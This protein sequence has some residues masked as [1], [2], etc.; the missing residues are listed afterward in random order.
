MKHD[1]ERAES[2]I[3]ETAAFCANHDLGMYHA[4]TVGAAALV[5]LHRGDWQSSLAHADEVL[6]QPALPPTPRILP[7]ICAALIRARRGEE[8]VA[9]LL[10]EALRAADPD[11]LSR[12]GGLGRPR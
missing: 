11:D 1:L 2:Y 9:A 4:I 7:Q 10:D 6:T 3:S 12:R 5:A 8:P